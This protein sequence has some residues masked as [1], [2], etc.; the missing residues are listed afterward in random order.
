MRLPQPASRWMSSAPNARH[1]SAQRSPNFPQE[2]TSA[3]SP[4]RTRLATA[5]SMAPDPDA[6]NASTS[7]SVWK[8][9]FSRP[10][11]RA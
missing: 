9:S 10:R 1:S 7:F 5:D 11:Q 3:G 2:A 4:G 6:A 8:T